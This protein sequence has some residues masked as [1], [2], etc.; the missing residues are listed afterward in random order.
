MKKF[1]IVRLGCP[2]NDADMDN[3]QGLLES[4]GYLYEKEPEDSDLIFIDT[5]G[6]IEEAK[7]ESI[8]TIFEYISLK[9]NHKNLRVIAL[10]CLT[11]RYYNEIKEEIPE[12]DGIFGVISPK[13]VV[14]N[15]E[16]GL[17][18]FK[19][20]EPETIY[21]CESRSFPGSYY[22]YV[23]IGDGCSRNCTFCSIP[24]FKGKPKSREIEDIKS[25]VNFLVKNGVKEVILV[26]QDNSLYGV[27]IYKNQ[28]LPKLLDALNK[29]DGDF[30]IRVMYLHP[31]FITQE[32][33]DSIHH[34]EKVLNYF[35]IPIQ[36]ISDDILN[37]MGRLKKKTE[38]I[39]IIERIRKEPSA[40]RTTLMLGFPGE[41]SK[42]FEELMEFVKEVKFERL[43]SFR[44]SKEDGTK[45]FKMIDQVPE[46]IKINRQKELMEL[47]SKISKEILESYVGKIMKVLVEEKENGVYLARSYLDAPEIDGNVFLK[48]DEDLKVGE[49]ANVLISRAYE[50]DLEGELKDE[51]PKLIESK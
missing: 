2:K 48:E 47:Q 13:T 18:F 1:H 39:K 7:R 32:I 24:S 26:S 4:K 21:K 27:D 49:F 11:E 19:S 37:S 23:K 28:A 46:K 6:F 34:N 29:I 35:D 30:W 8:E 17:L 51:C 5:C 33:I 10:G 15:V 16:R 44:Y 22:A 50:Y 36:H 3:L 14:D 45:A 40:I 31:D 41:T 25:E 20:N 12:L 9:E 43:G 38:I 42:D